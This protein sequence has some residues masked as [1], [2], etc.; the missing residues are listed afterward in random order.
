MTYYKKLLNNLTRRKIKLRTFM[1][2][3]NIPQNKLRYVIAAI[4][5]GIQKKTIRK[6]NNSQ[7][8]NDL[9]HSYSLIQCKIN[10]T[11]N[12]CSQKGT[13]TPNLCKRNQPSNRCAKKQQCFK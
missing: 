9:D 8:L 2:N 6:H 1:R 5:K 13:S 10:L 3:H 7:A 4:K 11:S 12:R